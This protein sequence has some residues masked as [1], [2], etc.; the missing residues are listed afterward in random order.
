P[1]TY[2]LTVTGTATATHSASV[3]LTVTAPPPPNDFSIGASPTSLSLV[4]GASG[5]STISPAFT[6]GTAESINLS[7]TGTPVGATGTLSPTS[8]TTGVSSPPLHDAL[9]ISPGT[10]TLTVTGMAT[11]THTTTVT[12]T[13][14][15]LPPSD[16]FSIGASPTS[17]SLVQGQ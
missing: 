6:R 4:Q 11:A 10:Y 1:G 17:L 3:T 12:L 7:V 13:V 2:T 5:T 15:A 16:D 14:T 8:A 9:P